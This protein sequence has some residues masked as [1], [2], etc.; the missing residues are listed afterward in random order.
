MLGVKILTADELMRSRST[1]KRVAG[2]YLRRSSDRQDQSVG[3]QERVNTK[4]AEDLGCDAVVYFID[5]ALTGTTVKGRNDF[6]V[7]MD[8]ALTP[9]SPLYYVIPYDIKRFSRGDNIETGYWLY[10]LRENGVRVAYATEGFKGDDSDDLVR[11]VKQWLA[12][13]ESKDLSKVTFRG[14]ISR[15][16]G[17]WWN[18]GEP[19]YGY[20][21]EYVDNAGKAYMR[22]RFN[23]DRT[24]LVLDLKSGQSRILPIGQQVTT[25]K[26]DRS[27][28]VLSSSDRVALVRRIFHFYT[29]QGL[30]FRRIADTLNREGILSPRGKHWSVGT[31]RSIIQ[32]RIYVGDMVWNRRVRGRFHRVEREHAVER[33][34]LEA[35]KLRFSD[36]TDWLI[37]EDAHP[38]IIDR[39]TFLRAQSLLHR[40]RQN[41]GSD[42]YRHG[43]AMNS[44]FLLS[45]VMRCARCGHSLIGETI[46]SSK[47]RKD[48]TR[49]VTQYY[50]C[51]GYKNKGN[52]VCPR[53]AIRIEVIH[54]YVLERIGRRVDAML[55]NGGRNG[56]RDLLVRELAA[57]QPYTKGEHGHIQ[58]ELGSIQSKIDRLV[59]ALASMDSMNQEV[60]NEKLKALVK[61]R[62]LL[63]SRLKELE[64]IQHEEVNCDA[65]A[66]EIM[67][68]VRGFKGLFSEGTPE[69]KKEFIRL[70]LDGIDFD[71]EERRARV[72]MKR[73]PAPSQDTGKSSFSLVAGAGF[74][75]ATFGV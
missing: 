4:T 20:D 18:G 63:K 39:S 41:R 9:G 54:R 35:G 32:N 55:S 67:A 49:I 57:N 12:R 75:P 33:D 73:F 53:V 15:A 2:I 27:R 17:G 19:P 42:A 38:A 48:G 30:G 46:G 28:L 31:I 10:R 64:P 22:V 40:R 6:Q 1:F 52:T 47:V 7:M 62:D 69:E 37:R 21:L 11:S 58:E 34:E 50:V 56:L 3:D 25:A 65:I 5:D 24:K 36:E 74:E 71:P 29:H 43:R 66:D 8:I 72:Y 26:S 14:L 23:S 44:D 60:I 59:N 13:Q 70:W 68:S 16:H 51:A 61:Q 45:G